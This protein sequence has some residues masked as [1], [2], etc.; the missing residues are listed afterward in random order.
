MHRSPKYVQ[1]YNLILKMIKNA[2]FPVGSKLPSEKILAEEFAI[3]RVT[4]R[5][6]LSLL[7]EDGVIQSIHGQG[8]FVLAENN[9][10]NTGI[11]TLN[12]PIAKSLTISI[13]ERES[14]YHLNPASTFTDRLF[15]TQG[16][17]YYTIN[18]WY[19]NN[20]KNIANAFVITK[21]SVVDKLNIKLE[22]NNSIINFIEHSLYLKAS[23]SKLVITV[24]DR[25]HT[26]FK[27]GF[28]SQ[29]PLILMKEDLFTLH[30]ERLS[31]NKF[32][33]PITYFRTSLMRYPTAI[34]NRKA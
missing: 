5:T 1:I 9:M 10:D 21:P 15:K 22:K 13:D 33:I 27:Q 23:N 4:L 14:Y 17:P 12:T 7:R 25:K 28:G 24:S 16:M 19:K 26:T 18:I 2:Q 8:H 20:G 31:Q 6:A 11:E 30:D 32:Y 3:S 29:S 34:Q